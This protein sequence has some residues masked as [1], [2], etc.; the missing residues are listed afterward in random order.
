MS[1]FITGQTNA[2]FTD[3]NTITGTIKAG[4]WQSTLKIINEGLQGQGTGQGN[5]IF[6]EVQNEGMEMQSSGMYEV[7]YSETGD[8]Q[9]EGNRIFI[10]TFKNDKKLKDGQKIDVKFTPA[11]NGIYKFKV[12]L[13]DNKNNAIW[14]KS[15]VVTTKEDEQQVEEEQE[16]LVEP[17]KQKKEEKQ[18]EVNENKAAKDE[19][20]VEEKASEQETVEEGMPNEL[21]VK[22]TKNKDE[23]PPETTENQ[24]AEHK[25]EEVTSKEPVAQEQSAKQVPTLDKLE[26]SNEQ[27][28][29]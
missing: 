15:I 6:A 27:V 13:K 14:S 9:L 25:A 11:K 28:G 5:E 21:P 29:E 19:I 18:T 24:P 8:P 23:T 20:I 26:N 12:F 10:D 4:T 3:S 1:T 7:Y 2:Y 16:K 17:E 22:E